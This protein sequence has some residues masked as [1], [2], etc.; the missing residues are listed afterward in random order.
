MKFLFLIPL[1]VWFIIQW[2]KVLIDYTV[3]KKVNIAS[4]WWSWWFP[5]VHS[6]IASSI[7]TLVVIIAWWQSIEF[8]IAFTFSFL[9]WYDAANLR[10]E[11]WQHASSLNQIQKELNKSTAHLKERLW[12][13]V[14]EVIWWI[15]AWVLLTLL[16]ATIFMN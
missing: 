2:I 9:F 4:L 1:C 10:Y 11:A 13:T 16:F 3:E 6:G 14:W 8:A 12:H 15:L 7:C 5:S